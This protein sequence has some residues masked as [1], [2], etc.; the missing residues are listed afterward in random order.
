[1]APLDDPNLHPRFKSLLDTLLSDNRQAWELKPDGSYVQRTPNGESQ[2]T[3]H[4]IF[5][6]SSWGELDQADAG[7][8]SIART[9]STP[10]AKTTK[11]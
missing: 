4:E 2:R 5:L 8:Q 6:G 1:V 9:E 10:T 11:D 7:S 3:A